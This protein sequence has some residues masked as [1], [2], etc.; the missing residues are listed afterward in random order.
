[1]LRVFLILIGALAMMS[2]S[3]L[4]MNHSDGNVVYDIIKPTTS[5]DV[6]PMTTV[7]DSKSLHVGKELNDTIR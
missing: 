3:I 2:C 4:I 5:T 1:M 6:A 7:D